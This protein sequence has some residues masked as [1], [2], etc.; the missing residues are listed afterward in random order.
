MRRG[1]SSLAQLRLGKLT[2]VGAGLKYGPAIW[3]TWVLP[4]IRVKARSV[5]WL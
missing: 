1:L 2:E 5:S 4:W 3:P